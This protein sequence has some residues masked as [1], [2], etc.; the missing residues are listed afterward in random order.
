MIQARALIVLEKT[1]L[2]SRMKGI[3]FFY[4]KFQI[5]L[6]GLKAHVRIQNGMKLLGK[7]DGRHGNFQ[8]TVASNMLAASSKLVTSFFFFLR[9]C[10]NNFFLLLH[11]HKY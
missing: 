7:F 5:P 2:P 1:G 6:D 10:E 8:G 4:T 9:T 11:N 3:T